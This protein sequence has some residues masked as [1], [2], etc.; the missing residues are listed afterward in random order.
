[1]P[2]Q[3]PNEY[4]A[5]LDRAEPRLAG[6]SM[7]SEAERRQEAVAAAPAVACPNCSGLADHVSDATAGDLPPYPIAGLTAPMV[8]TLQPCGCRVSAEWTAEFTAEVTRRLEGREPRAVVVPEGVRKAQLA[9]YQKHLT[10]LYTVQRTHALRPEQRAAVERWIV[11]C[12]DQIQRLC[13]GPHNQAPPPQTG[14]PVFRHADNSLRPSPAYAG[15]KPDG[16]V[17]RPEPAP[18]WTDIV[19][20]SR[21][22]TDAILTGVQAGLISPAAAT[23][24]LGLTTEP[25]LGR[26]RNGQHSVRLGDIYRVFV[27]EKEAQEYATQLRLAPGFTARMTPPP[28]VPGPAAAPPPPPPEVLPPKHAKRRRSLRR[29]DDDSEKS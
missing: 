5:S 6:A 10:A 4:R 19:D 25:K 21:D 12:G 29:L 15:Q 9:R 7:L 2:W 20:A 18:T 22:R 24:A 23:E 13:P 28:A 3:S 1:M 26:T 11:V 16:H 14:V 8:F 27:T 17:P